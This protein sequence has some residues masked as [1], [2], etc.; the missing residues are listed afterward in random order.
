MSPKLAFRYMIPVVILPVVI[1]AI[2]ATKGPHATCT[3]WIISTYSCMFFMCPDNLGSMRRLF[4]Q[5]HARTASVA[6]AFFATPVCRRLVAN[7]IHCN[8]TNQQAG[9]GLQLEAAAPKQHPMQ[10]FPA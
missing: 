7:N 10:A 4:C 5:K 6:A 3:W 1:V 2:R 9:A 8:G